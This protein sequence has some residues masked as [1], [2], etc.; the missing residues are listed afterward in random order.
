MARGSRRTEPCRS[1]LGAQAAESLRLRFAVTDTSAAFE[2]PL[3]RDV[4]LVVRRAVDARSRHMGWDL[5][6]RDRRLAD[7]PN[8][9]YECL[10]GHGPRPHDYY[11]WHFSMEYYPAERVLPVFGYPL[12]VRV[13]C[14][15]CSVAGRDAEAHFT[16]GT[17]EI[18]VRRLRVSNPRQKRG[19]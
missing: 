14:A 15:D 9:F 2:V 8:F 4:L 7:S 13:R 10:C 11:A 17:I 16:A 19:A 3:S 18:F 1:P 5:V 12:D 6:A